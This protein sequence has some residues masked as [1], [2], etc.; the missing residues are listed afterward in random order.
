MD[1][2]RCRRG[3]QGG[4]RGERRWPRRTRFAVAV[5]LALGLWCLLVLALR[6]AAAVL[7]TLAGL[8]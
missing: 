1:P 4:R 5:V 7:R 8:A 2:I 6:T 3:P